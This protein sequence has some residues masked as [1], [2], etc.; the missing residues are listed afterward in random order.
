M[1]SSNNWRQRLDLLS[2]RITRSFWR[3]WNKPPLS[4]IINRGSTPWQFASVGSHRRSWWVASSRGQRLFG[5]LPHPR[6]LGYPGSGKLRWWI[7]ERMALW[8]RQ[9]ITKPAPANK[10]KPISTQTHQQPY[11]PELRP[12]CIFN[13]FDS[14]SHSVGIACTA[15]VTV[16]LQLWWTMTSAQHCKLKTQLFLVEYELPDLGRI[17]LVKMKPS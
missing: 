3:S 17:H 2:T 13:N 10:L 6:S 9:P 1:N 16:V 15:T 4:S 8:A 12:T 11:D 7:E 14:T 5:L